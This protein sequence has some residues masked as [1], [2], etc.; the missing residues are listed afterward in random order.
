MLHAY[1]IP[2]SDKNEAK[3]DAYLISRPEFPLSSLKITFSKHEREFIAGMYMCFWLE[4]VGDFHDDEMTPPLC[5]GTSFELWCLIQYFAKCTTERSRERYKERI[6]R[7]YEN[8]ISDG[9]WS[10][11][12]TQFAT[13]NVEDTKPLTEHIL[14]KISRSYVPFEPFQGFPFSEKTRY[15]A[16]SE[17]NAPIIEAIKPLLHDF[18][19]KTDNLEYA[20]DVLSKYQQ[21]LNVSYW[22]LI[23][24]QYIGD[25][26]YI[27][28]EPDGTPMEVWFLVSLSESNGIVSQKRRSI[29]FEMAERCLGPIHK[30][31]RSDTIDN[32][33]GWIKKLDI[34]ECLGMWKYNEFTENRQKSLSAA[35]LGK[36]GMFVAHTVDG[37]N[38][39]DADDGP[40]ARHTRPK[41]QQPITHAS[42]AAARSISP[43]RSISPIQSYWLDKL[44]EL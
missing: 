7:I 13:A 18:P 25:V 41:L 31:P 11:L 32:N 44:D 28:P 24:A 16:I 9:V 26:T 1:K 3:I 29:S 20:A 33:L 14:K 21:D 2:K 35:D 4:N 19:W 38:G 17:N 34:K 23:C 5:K 15:A 8:K 12:M 40:A 36:R 27:S 10:Q 22:Q 30:N 42:P 6:D 39:D 43:T 37:S